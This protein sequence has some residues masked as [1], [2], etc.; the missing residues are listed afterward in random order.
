MHKTLP[1]LG[2]LIIFFIIFLGTSCLYSDYK[3][4]F[5]LIN[6]SG[7]VITIVRVEICGQTIEI[8][9]IK[10]KAKH[11]GVYNVISDSHYDVT[12]HFASGEKLEK[13]LGYVTRG[14]DYKHTLTVTEKDITLSDVKIE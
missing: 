1:L 13:K 3:G 9:D 8:K 10:Q 5:K 12:V 2:Y 14:F 4:Q 7:K 6:N 11:Q